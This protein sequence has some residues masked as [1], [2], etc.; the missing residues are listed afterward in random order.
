M[1]RRN[2]YS[3]GEDDGIDPSLAVR[4]DGEMDSEPD[5]DD[6]PA[7]T[8]ARDGYE[9]LARRARHD[10]P[11]NMMRPAAAQRRDEFEHEYGGGDYGPLGLED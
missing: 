4:S 11:G 8:L 10:V 1:R 3:Y 2:V 5:V 7:P 6:R 9:V